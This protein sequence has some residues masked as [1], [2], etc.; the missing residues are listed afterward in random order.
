[1]MSSFELCV[2]NDGQMMSL[3][4]VHETRGEHRE[5]MGYVFIGSCSCAITL[6]LLGSICALSSFRVVESSFTAWSRTTG[7]CSLCVLTSVPSPTMTE[8]KLIIKERI[9]TW[10]IVRLRNKRPIGQ[11]PTKSGSLT[12]RSNRLGKAFMVVGWNNILKAWNEKTGLLYEF[13]QFKN[14]TVKLGIV[15]KHRVVESRT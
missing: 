12:S 10:G 8:A 13:L 5:D 1:M 6:R 9:K 4:A 14:L 11:C 7:I 15:G 2:T 3:I